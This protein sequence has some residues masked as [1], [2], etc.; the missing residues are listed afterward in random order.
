MIGAISL[1]SQFHVKE[2]LCSSSL[3]KKRKIALFLTFCMI[4][5][6]GKCS[7]FLVCVSV[8]EF[9][10]S[11]AVIAEASHILRWGL[12]FSLSVVR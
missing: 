10:V 2:S 4:R 11:M 6:D 8:D 1:G 3:L 9:N 12:P 5:H 7:L